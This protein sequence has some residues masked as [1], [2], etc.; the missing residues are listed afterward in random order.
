MVTSP[1]PCGPDEVE[2]GRMV[3]EPRP[4]LVSV[5]IPKYRVP[6]RVELPPVGTEGRDRIVPLLSVE[7]AATGLGSCWKGADVLAARVMT[8]LHPLEGQS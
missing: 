6:V 4:L 2:V 5:P 8:V 3:A 7:K 1:A